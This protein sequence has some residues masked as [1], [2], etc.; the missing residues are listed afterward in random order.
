MR[1]SPGTYRLRM[2]V[3]GLIRERAFELLGSS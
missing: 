3:D 1:L 2:D